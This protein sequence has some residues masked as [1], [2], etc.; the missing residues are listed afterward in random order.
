MDNE[1]N[2]HSLYN[3]LLY[4]HKIPKHFRGCL[5][6]VSAF[7][8][9]PV[10]MRIKRNKDGKIEYGEGIEV[11]LLHEMVEGTKVSTLYRPPLADNG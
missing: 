11:N 9:P 1:S 6:R 7:E 4:P 8:Y 3:A 2:G 10:G 5:L